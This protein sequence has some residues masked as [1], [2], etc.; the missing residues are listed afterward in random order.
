MSSLV[1]KVGEVHCASAR[2][3]NSAG[4]AGDAIHQIEVVAALL[5]KGAAR[6]FRELIPLSDL[7]EKGWAVL[8]ET[9]H[10][11]R[12]QLVALKCRERKLVLRFIAVLR[13]IGWVLDS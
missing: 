13:P 10:L 5:N 9:D 6:V 4:G 12:S 1:F 3:V 2:G 11:H 7:W 8:T